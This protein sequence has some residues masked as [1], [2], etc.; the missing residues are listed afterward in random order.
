M[1]ATTR[2]RKLKLSAKVLFIVVI[3]GPTVYFIQER[4]ISH[5]KGEREDILPYRPEREQFKDAQLLTIV[6]LPKEK[7]D[8]D[9]AKMIYE[10]WGAEHYKFAISTGVDENDLAHLFQITD[11]SDLTLDDP[12]QLYCL[13]KAI[14][15]TSSDEYKWFFITSE[16]VYPLVENI[17]HALIGLNSDTF[18][19][20]GEQLQD[21]SSSQ[22][23]CSLRS[24]LLLSR[25]ALQTIV[26]ELESCLLSDTS[27]PGD[28]ILGRCIATAVHK[29]CMKKKDVSVLLTLSAH[30]QR[31][32]AV[33]CVCVCIC[34][35][36]PT[37]V[38]HLLKGL[39]FRLGDV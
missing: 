10:T 3:L 29:S 17:R 32:I 12:K 25:K 23:Y 16:V 9:V 2:S 13:L 15:Y 24:G 14:Y 8:S 11:C 34:L 39:F 1:S 20:M 18:L 35:M 33:S 7:L 5:A 37:L 26:E 6:A 21:N 28:V 22:Q 30:A 4:L 38:R 36:H 31:V 19:Y 27:G